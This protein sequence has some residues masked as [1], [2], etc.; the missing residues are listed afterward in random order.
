[1]FYVAGLGHG[2]P[3]IVGNVYLEKAWSNIYPNV[4]QGEAGLKKHFTQFSFSN[5]ISNHVAFT[6]PRSIHEWDNLL[7]RLVT[8]SELPSII[9]I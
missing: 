1:M 9:L 2:G 8:P 6:T 3:A 5:G 4:T 7:I